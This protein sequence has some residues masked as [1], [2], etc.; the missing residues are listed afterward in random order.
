MTFEKIT[1]KSGAEYYLAWDDGCVV[2]NIGDDEG[3]E[4]WLE[5]ALLPKLIEFAKKKERKI[6]N[7][8]VS[9]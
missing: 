3:R 4:I 8:K 9:G 2:V 1:L 6:T 5:P 7:P